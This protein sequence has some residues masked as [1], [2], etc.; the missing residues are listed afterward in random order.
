MDVLAPP[1]AMYNQ[2]QA[3]E[4]ASKQPYY[5]LLVEGSDSIVYFFMGVFFFLHKN[6]QQAQSLVSGGSGGE[7]PIRSGVGVLFGPNT[8]IS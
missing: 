4:I 7:S 5:P 1:H 2:H 8:L 3:N 6:G